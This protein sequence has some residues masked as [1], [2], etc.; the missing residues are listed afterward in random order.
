MEDERKLTQ[1]PEVP[2]ATERETPDTQSFSP[3]SAPNTIPDP[4]APD[5]QEPDPGVG[6]EPDLLRRLETQM[7]A[8]QRTQRRLLWAVGALAALLVLA[9]GVLF[10]VGAQA[11][12]KVEA[13]SQQAEEV[14]AMLEDSLGEL[15]PEALDGLMQT[16]PDI[17][18][19]L[20]K[21]DVDALNGTLEALPEL[22]ESVE[23]MEQQVDQLASLFSG[24]SRLFG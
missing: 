6:D 11:Y 9:L 1:A 10:T 5:P 4:D 8:M 13:A 21:I 18:D 2:E 23:R 24:L 17:A 14:S 19:R 7:L 12:E 3:P 16:L 22:M 20:A 15:D